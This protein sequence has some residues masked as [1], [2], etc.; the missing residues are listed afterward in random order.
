MLSVNREDFVG[1]AE[2]PDGAFAA[3]VT[4]NDEWFAVDLSGNVRGNPEAVEREAMALGVAENLIAGAVVG[5]ARLA[6]RATVAALFILSG[7]AAN[8]QPAACVDTTASWSVP[9]SQGTIQA[10]SYYLWQQPPPPPMKRPPL[11][12]VLYRSGELHVHVNVPTGI[13]QQFRGLTSA[14]QKYVQLVQTKYQQTMLSEGLC[15]LLA[16]DSNYLLGQRP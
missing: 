15:P 9:Y 6:R 10:I 16:E 8:A 7:T 4:A 11:L 13:A 1:R 2:I 5:L 12:S 3:I 14:D